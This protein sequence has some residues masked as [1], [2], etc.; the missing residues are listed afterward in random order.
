MKTSTKIIKLLILG[1]MLNLMSF[2]IASA[3]HLSDEDYGAIVK[4]ILVKNQIVQDDLQISNMRVSKNLASLA[5]ALTNLN[6]PNQE[7]HSR[8]VT[9]RVDFS[10]THHEIRNYKCNL[11]VEINNSNFEG[12]QLSSCEFTGFQI[13]R[14]SL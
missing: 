10:Q 6:S 11:N 14:W 13:N 12:T 9:F 8:I 2:S 5:G 4:S 1:L 7:I 3:H